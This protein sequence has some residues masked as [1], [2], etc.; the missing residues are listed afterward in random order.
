MTAPQALYGEIQ[1][2][3]GYYMMTEARMTVP[4]GLGGGLHVY[5]GMRRLKVGESYK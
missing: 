4:R 5:N 1:S 3:G 2:V